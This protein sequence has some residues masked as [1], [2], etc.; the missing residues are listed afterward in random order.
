MTVSTPDPT[1]FRVA[2]PSAYPSVTSGQRLMRCL[3]QR[4]CM[5]TNHRDVAAGNRHQQVADILRYLR[6]LVS[7]VQGAGGDAIPLEG[8]S[9]LIT[10]AQQLLEDPGTQQANRT[11][12]VNLR[13]FVWQV[14]MFKEL[15]RGGASVPM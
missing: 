6:L 7:E 8:S 14:D 12:V 5:T 9:P 4:R 3:L 10:M 11:A 13:D 15:V 2:P 1:A